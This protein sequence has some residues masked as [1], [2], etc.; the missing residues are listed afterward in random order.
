MQ[1]PPNLNDQHNW[2]GQRFH[3]ISTVSPTIPNEQDQPTLVAR[4]RQDTQAQPLSQA[5]FI[6]SSSDNLFHPVP[7]VPSSYVFTLPNIPS[8][9]RIHAYNPT[10]TFQH[11]P[12]YHSPFSSYNNPSFAIPP[13]QNHNHIP[14]P[15]VN[16]PLVQ[17]P[18]IPHPV[19]PQ[20][21]PFNHPQHMYNHSQPLYNFHQPAFHHPQ[22]VY[23][24]PQ[25][26]F[27]QFPS[28]QPAFQH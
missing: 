13:R 8:D 17:P 19:L 18:P 24:Q 2:G 7:A 15:P 6:A 11:C 20:P 16:P 9:P 22:P 21:L 4:G 25:P 12:P 1:T 10:N 28:A 5:G 3:A 26:A 23:H 14:S 27:Q